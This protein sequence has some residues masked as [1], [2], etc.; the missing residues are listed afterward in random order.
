MIHFKQAVYIAEI[1]DLGKAKEPIFIGYFINRKDA[2]EAGAF[3]L[4]YKSRGQEL[5]VKSETL[6]IKIFESV[7]EYIETTNLELIE[8]AKKKLTQEEFEAI[9]DA[10]KNNSL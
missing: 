9:T 8:R 2:N 3:V 5:N 6:E 7:S 1:K 4:K 10:I